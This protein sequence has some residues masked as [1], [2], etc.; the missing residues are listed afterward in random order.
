VLLQ[1]ML[2]PYATFRHAVPSLVT[3]V[4]VLY[5]TRAGAR[6]GSIVALAGG[7]LDDVFAG[8]GCAWLVAT[9]AVVL[10]VGIVSRG[11]FSDGFVTLG[12]LVALSVGVRDAVFWSVMR[13][14]GYPQGLGT[15]HVHAA[16]WQAALTGLVTIVYLVARSR[17]FV[18]RTS[19]ERYP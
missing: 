8:T 6:R 13:L 5:S 11:F 17:F 15:E 14:A 12:G 3:I 4:V 9:L 16:L 1:T 2:A 19:V 18:D 7:A 10:F